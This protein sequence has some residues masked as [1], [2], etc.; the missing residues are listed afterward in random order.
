MSKTRKQPEAPPPSVWWRSK[1]GIPF[2]IKRTQH[3]NCSDEWLYR[4]DFG[5][6]L[7]TGSWSWSDLIREGCEPL[8]EQPTDWEM[9]ERRKRKPTEVDEWA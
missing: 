7:G 5:D 6:I 4:P 3:Y 8:D 1:N 2:K 9:A